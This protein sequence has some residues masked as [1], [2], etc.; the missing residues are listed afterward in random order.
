MFY[1]F[2]SPAVK[3]TEMRIRGKIDS[4]LRTAYADSGEGA[5]LEI[6]DFIEM[7]ERDNRFIITTPPKGMGFTFLVPS[8][9][10]GFYF[11]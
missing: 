1:I 6:F 4:P 7:R 3:V 10:G 9:G 11:F 2:P 5:V 8:L